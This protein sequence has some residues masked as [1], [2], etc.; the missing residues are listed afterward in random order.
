MNGGLTMG[1][2][3]DP[4][5]RK[6]EYLRVSVV[7]SCNLRCFYC[8]PGDACKPRSVR[9][10]LKRE[11][12]V[13]VVT[14]AAEAGIRK[15]RLTGG[16]PLVRKDIVELVRDIA[17]VPG[18][19]DLSLTTNGTLLKALAV[20]LAAAGLKRVNISLDSL[21]VHSFAEITCGGQL[22]A[23][24]DGIQAAFDAGLTPIKINMVV[25][26]GLNDHE[27]ENFARMTHERNIH[28]RFIEYMPMLGQEEVWKKH[29]LPSDEIMALCRQA[30]PMDPLPEED[31]NGPAR[32]FRYPGAVGMLGFITPV[33]QHFCANCNRLRLTSDGKLKPCLF[34]ADEIDLRPALHAGS[35]LAPFFKEA[36]EKKPAHGENAP[37]AQGSTCG[38]RGMVEIGG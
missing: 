38:P 2:L 8:R 5:G 29:Y 6:L 33:S 37:A 20:P 14:A 27:V 4:Y 32:N 15:V 13:R 9:G 26:K 24:L 30:G 36:A 7:D 3:V 10:Q 28:I 11:N 23:T 21:D 16:E 12:I 18:I 25:M 34:S 31:L 35:D 19:E 17:H 22:Q 1:T